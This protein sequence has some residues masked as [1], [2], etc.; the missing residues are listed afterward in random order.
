MNQ[1]GLHPNKDLTYYKLCLT[2]V[3]SQ[4]NVFPSDATIKVNC[5]DIDD[6][7]SSPFLLAPDE[8]QS[9]DIINVR[10]RICVCSQTLTVVRGGFNIDHI[11]VMSDGSSPAAYWARNVQNPFGQQTLSV[12]LCHTHKTNHLHEQMDAHKDTMQAHNHNISHAHTFD[13]DINHLHFFFLLECV[14]IFFP[15]FHK[16][17]CSNLWCVFHQWEW[18]WV[19]GC[20]RCSAMFIFISFCSASTNTLP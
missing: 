11:V 12:S 16:M 20:K 14:T 7:V 8:H 18:Y 6:F 1:T 10:S 19:L 17:I 15:K 9:K 13:A 5:F 3:V 4:R 2:F